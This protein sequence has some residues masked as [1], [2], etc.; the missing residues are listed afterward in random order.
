VL[1][2]VIDTLRADRLGCYGYEAQ[3]TTPTMDRLAAEGIVFERF[4]A[5]SPWT[6]ASFGSILTGVSPQVHRAGA[7]AHKS[8]K[9]AES[10]MGVRTTPLSKRI[11]MLPELLGEIAT[12]AIMTNSFLH[13]SMGFD[14]GFDHY[15]HRNAGLDKSRRADTTTK[16]AVAWLEDHH[17]EPFFLLVHYF[18][19]HMSYDPPKQYLAEFAPGPSG[20]IGCPFY[21]HKRARSGELDPNAK[22]QAFIRGL[23]NAEVR[24]VDDQ[25]G[26]LID[27]MKRLGVFDDTWLMITSDHGEEQFDHDSFDHGHR[28]EE[29]VVR[30]PLII[31][32]PDGE[33]K[34]GTRIPY[35]TRHIDLAPTILEWTGREPAPSMAGQSLMPLITGEEAAHRPA[36]M[37]FNIY[38]LSRCALFD[39]RYK[40]IRATD[41]KNGW[42][43]DLDEDPLEQKKLNRSHPRYAPLETQ[44]EAVRKRLAKQ[45]SGTRQ[46]A[47][48][49]ELPP[50]VVESLRSLGY[51][52]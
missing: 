50:E 52:D 34:A 20:R 7:R 30:V 26:E 51:I 49:I 15:D 23:Y 6:G 9:N 46:G 33:W 11:P 35:S 36:Y 43:Y 47:E 38:W 5:A 32:P 14:R 40:L 39:G 21:D 24:F 12:A 1:L 25:I 45:A 37:E 31:R 22:E 48:E 27:A 44:L 29:E 8:S 10:I 42:L 41:S 2:I 28:Y 16:A 18:D 3:P 19:P 17:A 13:P 4:H